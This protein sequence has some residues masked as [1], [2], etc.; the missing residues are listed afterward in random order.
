[1]I[2]I[3]DNGGTINTYSCNAPLNGYKY[4]FGEGGIRIPLIVSMPSVLPRNVVNEQ[5]DC[6]PSPAPYAYP[7]GILLFDLKEDIGE[8]TNLADERPDIVQAM[9][10]LHRTWDSRMGDPSRPKP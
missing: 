7:N 4:M 6:V 1:M 2:F 5:G 9:M 10:A 3:S 8:T